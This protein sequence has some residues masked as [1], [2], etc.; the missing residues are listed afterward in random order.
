MI[1]AIL[2]SIAAVSLSVLGVYAAA[3]QRTAANALLFSVLL[4][5][6]GIEIFDQLSLLTSSDV[7]TFRPISS[8]LESLLPA[9][10]LLLSLTYGRTMPRDARSKLRF[11]LTVVSALFPMA[12]LLVAG[13]DLYY[14]PDFQNERVLFLG[15]AGYWFY[16]GITALL[17]V[18]LV[19]VEA[20]LV[21]TRGIARHRM[22][23]E[24]FG[25][26][27]LLAVLIFYY[28]QGLLYRTINMNLVPIRSSVFIVASLLVGYSRAVRGNGA[29]VMVSRHVLFRSMTLLVVGFYL[30]GLGLIGE[31]MRYFGVAFGRNLTI[32][33]AFAGGILLLAFLF[34][35]KV[36]RR[37]KVYVSKHFYA[38]KHDY[39][40][41]WIKFTTRLASCGTL[42]D[43]QDAVLTV[44]R[45][46]FGLAGASLYLRGR[47]E[48]RYERFAEQFMTESPAE[49]LITDELFSYF[50]GH[51][52]VL[53]ITDR[54]SP[55]SV[56]EK[57][58]FESGKIW[59]VVPLITTGRIEALVAL[60]GQIVPEKLTFEDYDLMK[61]FARQA[62]Q[63]I[64]NLRLSEELMEIQIGR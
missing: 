32:F 25:I 37:A 27:S 34:S 23:F 17:I 38:S 63:A 49:L 8:Y 39:R 14:S 50:I 44:Y 2:A 28:S 45:E 64:A 62:A 18:A 61:V 43:V 47:D 30:L 59:L 1:G 3:K 24:A 58:V 42:A 52:R 55:L 33:F 57:K 7:A 12:V 13:N 26:M 21:A 16:I 60:R 36:R 31:G 15:I 9:S 41:E 40:E 51:E 5:L 11:G 29:R 22:K 19:N 53:D 56:A 6:T 10:F 46:T 4:L 54:E 35:D 48:K 20:T